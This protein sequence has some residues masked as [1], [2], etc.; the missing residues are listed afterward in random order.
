[1]GGTMGTLH[2][3]TRNSLHSNSLYVHN[4]LHVVLTVHK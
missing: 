1:M 3:S 2:P 4:A